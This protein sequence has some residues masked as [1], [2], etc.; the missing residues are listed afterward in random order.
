MTNTCTDLRHDAESNLDPCVANS[1]VARG[2]SYLK[3]F[4]IFFF[5]TPLL[6]A[7]LARLFVRFPPKGTPEEF[8]YIDPLVLI[9]LFLTVGAVSSGMCFSLRNPTTLPKLIGE[10]FLAAIVCGMIC[11]FV[12]AFCAVRR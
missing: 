2:Q 10:A 6:G 5:G 11:F 3:W 7:I 4:W 1:R 8:Y 9:F 12:V